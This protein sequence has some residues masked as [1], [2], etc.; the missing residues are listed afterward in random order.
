MEVFKVIYLIYTIAVS[1]CA[2]S[3][4]P[5]AVVSTDC[6]PVLGINS[7]AFVF[8]GIPYA[9]PPLRDLRWTPPQAL[10]KTGGSCWKG[11]FNASTFGNTCIQRNPDNSSEIIG[12]ED[13]LYLNV[14]TPTLNSSANLPVMVWIHGGSL[15]LSN[16]NWPTYSP[17]VQLANSTNVVYVSMNYRLHAFGFMALDILTARSAHK[18]SGN[19]GF[20]DQQLALEWVQK[21]IKNFGG[22]PDLV[23]V[24]GQSSG[25]TSIIGLLAS[26]LSKGLFHRAWMM[27]AS[28]VYN[29]TLVEASK[30][31]LVFL[32]NT[33]CSDINCLVNVPADDIIHAIPWNV[34]P[35]WAMS[36]QMD[37]PVRNYFD[38]A[39]CIVDGYVVPEPPFDMWKQ[40]KGIDVPVIVGT[41]SQEVDFEPSHLDL[42]SWTWDTYHKYVHKY[43]DTFPGNLSAKALELYPD[44]VESGAYQYTTMTSDLRVTCPN[45]IMSDILSKYFKSPVYRYVLTFW[46]YQPVNIVGIPFQAH[47]ACHMWDAIAF[48][49]SISGYYK[50]TKGDQ[51]FEKSI[52]KE[53]VHFATTG[54]PYTQSWKTYPT[55]IGLLTTN[56]TAVSS[57]HA[58][59]CHFWNENNFF[60]YAWIN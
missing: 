12:S 25:G 59:M 30:D 6:G 45:N 15:Q 1:S 11:T 2:V 33:G 22:N 53:M 23:T 27:S 32:N 54:K 55:S 60:N 29:K 5:P 51:I 13:C 21:N 34:Y 56:V 39:I 52:Q 9:V 20:M 44:G 36:D 14:W 31:N 7:P 3:H 38:G 19:Y 47:Y 26:P 4:Q 8:K 16:G 10:G 18:T 28:P 50:P 42:N 40:G 58:E 43:L 35:Y 37:L 57:Y 24:F 48:F 41:T 46:P 49:G 17:T